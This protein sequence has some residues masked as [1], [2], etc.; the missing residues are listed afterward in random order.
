MQNTGSHLKVLDPRPRNKTLRLLEW[1]SEMKC[2]RCLRDEAQAAYR[3]FT[4]IMD[5]KV[6][7]GCAD[8]ARKLR[9]NVEPLD[10]GERKNGG[11]HSHEHKEKMVF[12][13]IFTCADA[14]H[15]RKHFSGSTTGIA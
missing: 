7:A 13:D 8:E 11:K 15:R 14:S 3:V 10:S 4:Q 2:E 1:R 12:E 9:I 6:C 5:M